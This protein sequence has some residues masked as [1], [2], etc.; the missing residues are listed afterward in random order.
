M[1]LCMCVHTHICVCMHVCMYPCYSQSIYGSVGIFKD[2]GW[3]QSTSD[4]ISS[5]FR[6]SNLIILFF[7]SSYKQTSM[8]GCHILLFVVGFQLR[9]SWN[10]W[11]WFFLIRAIML[12]KACHYYKGVSCNS[13]PK[14]GWKNGL[15]WWY[16][17]ISV[18]AKFLNKIW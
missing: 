3:T 4:P 9:W 16:G 10:Q 1:Y 14:A 2:S 7:P 18:W 17:M 11:P 8:F 5:E 13:W 6:F 15:V 12:F